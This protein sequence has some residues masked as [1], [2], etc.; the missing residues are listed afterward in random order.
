VQGQVPS[1][2]EQEVV[3]AVGLPQGQV[4]GG[5]QPGVFVLF[6]LVV[7]KVKVMCVVGPMPWNPVFAGNSF[8]SFAPM[9]AAPSLMSGVQ[10]DRT[11]RF[12]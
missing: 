3:K 1:H 11:Y 6:A 12:I 5:M 10:A 8:P 9:L 7:L 2:R 4:V